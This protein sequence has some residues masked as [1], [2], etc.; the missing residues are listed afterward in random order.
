MANNSLKLREAC[1]KLT[2]L[3]PYCSNHKGARCE[4]LEYVGSTRRG[5]H[6]RGSER[7]VRRRESE[8]T[9]E[10]ENCKFHRGKEAV[11]VVAPRRGAPSSIRKPRRNA[12]TE[13][14]VTASQD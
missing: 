1:C 8:C 5:A 3:L 6:D 13:L 7:I 9:P 2:G 14:K 10:S 12:L 4:M 11:V